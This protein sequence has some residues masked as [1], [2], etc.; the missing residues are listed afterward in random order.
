MDGYARGL[1]TQRL[2]WLAPEFHAG[3][4][5]DRCPRLG[6]SQPRLVICPCPYIFYPMKALTASSAI[7]SDSL[8]I[9]NS[10][11]PMPPTWTPSPDWH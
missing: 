2:A 7:C 6:I 1:G 4:A 5:A 3:I 10:L 9:P 8:R 11:H